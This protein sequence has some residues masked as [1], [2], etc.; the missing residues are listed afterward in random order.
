MAGKKSSNTLLIAELLEKFPNSSKKSIARMAHKMYPLLY[1]EDGARTTI[2]YLTGSCG[3]KNRWRLK[4]KIIK[5]D[6][7]HTPQNPYGLPDSYADERPPY[8]LPKV[9]NDIL[10]VSDFHVPYHDNK[11]TACVI[12]YG[13][14]EKI[15]TLFINGDLLDFHH[16]SRFSHD[17]HKR[18]TRHEFEAAI[19]LLKSLRK[20]FPKAN[21]FYHKGNHDI[22]YELWLR[23]HPEIFHDE[24]YQLENR[25]NLS[26]LGIIMIDD[27]TITRAGKL[28]IHHGHYMFRGS[29][30]PVSPARTILLKAKQSMVCGHTHKIS[31]ATATNLDGHI[32]TCFS[33]GCLCEL[34]PD[35]NPMAN[36]NAHGFAHAR[37]RE[38]GSFTVKNFR[39]HN[40]KIL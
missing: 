29:S 2:R 20:A 15:N 6:S 10:I 38:D 12:E 28:S 21:I 3:N 25:L 13:R 17:P 5:H 32:Y 30:S 18:N 26:E 35:Y 39:I 36:D 24:Y 27:K 33:T 14:K 11:A 1:T 23:Q 34:S 16:L 22:R 19:Q 31:E 40:G 7:T 8:I 4:D 9:N 37:I